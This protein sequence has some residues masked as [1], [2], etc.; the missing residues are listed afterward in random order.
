M[1]PSILSAERREY[2]EQAINIPDFLK[3]HDAF[4]DRANFYI[5]RKEWA[6]IKYNNCKNRLD[7]AITD[8]AIEMLPQA[9]APPH[10]TKK[11]PTHPHP[12]EF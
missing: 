6:T 11:P 9:F 7:D 3:Q 1:E 8:L 10:Q 2:I 12:C 4:C 5:R